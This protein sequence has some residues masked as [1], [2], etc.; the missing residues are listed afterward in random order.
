MVGIISPRV[1][2]LDTGR[3]NLGVVACMRANVPCSNSTPTRRERDPLPARA[4]IP[5]RTNERGGRA[6][7][8]QPQTVGARRGLVQPSLF[9]SNEMRGSIGDDDR[10]VSF[11]CPGRYPGSPATVWDAVLNA[12]TSRGSASRT[13]GV[14]WRGGQGVG[15]VFSLVVWV[16]AGAGAHGDVGAAARISILFSTVLPPRVLYTHY[17]S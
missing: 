9:A 4:I 3:R 13:T 8:A 17:E 15:V 5:P 16:G 7:G 10:R 2:S 1:L 11:L 6:F 12:A 14:A